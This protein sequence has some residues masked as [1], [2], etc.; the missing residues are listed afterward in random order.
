MKWLRQI[1]VWW[2][3][4]RGWRHSGHLADFQ[5]KAIVCVGP[6]AG[7]R[8]FFA[9]IAVLTITG[10]RATMLLAPN[11]FRWPVGIALRRL[12]CKPMP[13]L[14]TKVELKKLMAS[15]KRCTLV[16]M[17]HYQSETS[18]NTYY[19]L[20]QELRL[21]LVL[22]TI[23]SKQRSIKILSEFLPTDQSDREIAFCDKV[24][25]SVR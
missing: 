13:L 22:V 20:A 9:G 18:A 14:N 2:Y 12:S 7:M 21:P 15:K 24:F 5:P 8:E 23:D 16:M 11:Q 10:Y 4:K 1:A 25:D 19:Q 3:R 17:R 6:V